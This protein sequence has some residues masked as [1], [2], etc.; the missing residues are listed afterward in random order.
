M[1]SNILAAAE[2]LVTVQSL[3]SL[4]GDTQSTLLEQECRSPELVPHSVQLVFDQTPV[5]LG[6]SSEKE[7]EEEI[8]LSWSR[9]RVRGAN[10]LTMIV[11][12]L[13]TIEVALETRLEDEPTEFERKRKRKRKRK[14]KMAESHTKGDKRRYTTRGVVQK[15]MGDALAANEVQTERNR[16]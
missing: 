15:L 10:V 7:D 13:A 1:E 12:D 16:R 14:G 3:A 4:R 9:K 2:E 11:S 5:N 6:V 8:P